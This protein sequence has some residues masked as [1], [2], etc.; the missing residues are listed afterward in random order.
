MCDL[1]STIKLPL[2]SAIFSIHGLIIL[3]YKLI[4]GADS[5]N[6][7]SAIRK[8]LFSS[9]LFKSPNLFLIGIDTKI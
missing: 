2:L 4:I 6:F 1:T 7:V 8:I 3:I 5:F 9:I